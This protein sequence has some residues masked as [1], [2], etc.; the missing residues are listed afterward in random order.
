MSAD[1]CAVRH[2]KVEAEVLQQAR[3][4]LWHGLLGPTNAKVPNRLKKAERI[5]KPDPW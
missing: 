3:A 1:S 5:Q 2:R 4:F